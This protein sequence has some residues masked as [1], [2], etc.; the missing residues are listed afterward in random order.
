MIHD[1][2]AVEAFSLDDHGKH[3]H[4]CRHIVAVHAV[5]NQV[6]GLHGSIDVSFFSC[7]CPPQE[8]LKIDRRDDVRFFVHAVEGGRHR[9][10]N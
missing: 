10:T 2:G 5:V 9:A 7:H 3:G 4:G 1:P 6:D 8:Q